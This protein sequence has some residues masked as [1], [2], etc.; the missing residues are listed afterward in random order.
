MPDFLN[1]IDANVCSP[2]AVRKK[3]S[4]GSARKKFLHK[5]SDRGKITETDNL[6][7]EDEFMKV[8]KG[9]F[10]AHINIVFELSYFFS[11]IS[12]FLIL[13]HLVELSFLYCYLERPGKTCKN[14]KAR[15]THPGG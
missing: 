7:D 5:T 8:S 9:R 4:A 11:L 13:R 3:G 15:S 14:N 6:D 10:Q 1:A 12:C 2:I